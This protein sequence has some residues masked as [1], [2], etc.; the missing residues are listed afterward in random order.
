MDP[1][2]R[3]FKILSIVCILSMLVVLL[4]TPVATPPVK[5]NPDRVIDSFNDDYGTTQSANGT[6]YNS[7]TTSSAIGNHRNVILTK[8]SGTGNGYAYAVSATSWYR[9]GADAG[10]KTTTQLTYDGSTDATT[11]S[12]NGLGNVNLEENGDNM[13]YMVLIFDD[14]AFDVKVTVYSD[15][16]YCSSLTRKIPGGIDSTNAG[17]PP[18]MPRPIIFIYDNFAQDA[19]CTG[20][21]ADFT[22]VG[23][24]QIFFS[25]ASGSDVIMDLLSTGVMDFGDADDTGLT[26]QYYYTQMTDIWTVPP[27]ASKFTGNVYGAGHIIVSGSPRLGTYIDAEPDGQPTAGADGDDTGSPDD[28]DGVTQ[29]GGWTPGM[30][31]GGFIGVKTNG[32]NGCLYGWIDWNQDG[33]FAN[34]VSTTTA[35]SG[36]RVLDGIAVTS[37][38]STITYY[39]FPIP[40]DVAADAIVY[41]RFR[42]Y[43]RDPDGLCS[44]FSDGAEAYEKYP[45]A[46]LVYG[47]EVEDYLFDLG[48]TAVTV[49]N[50]HAQVAQS[51][52]GLQ[53]Q[54]TTV[55]EADTVGFNLYRAVL[56]GGSY[57]KINPDLIPAQVPGQSSGGDYSYTDTSAK[58]GMK[59]SYRLVQVATNLSETDYGTADGGYSVAYLPLTIH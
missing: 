45:Y 4:S 22:S 49:S 46:Y 6:Y 55:M 37:A 32:V 53:L 19:S 25:S 23:A 21:A 54:W 50:F 8:T 56:P 40:D 41:A 48:S 28:E 43:P 13:L 7:Y 18:T 57:I 15:S 33:D 26:N 34:S 29:E 14:L 38:N 30:D 36:D 24:I 47:G 31:P 35:G 10:V 27:P 1:K 12:P 44:V 17:T 59:Y 5:A 39:S 9:I 2:T 11:L 42:I 51:P 3:L 58:P 52:L 20:G 16:G